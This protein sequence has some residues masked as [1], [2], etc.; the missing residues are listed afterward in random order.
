MEGCNNFCSYCVVPYTRGRERSRTI[1]AVIKEA[2][3]IIAQGFKEIT[4]LGQNVD[5]YGKNL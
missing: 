3:D 2:K 5:S 1:E 4:L